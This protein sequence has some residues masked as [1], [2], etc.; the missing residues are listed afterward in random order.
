MKSQHIIWRHIFA[1]KTWLTPSN[2]LTL[3]RL[4]LAP[5]VVWFLYLG[6][7]PQAFITFVGAAATDLLDGHL[8]RAFDGQTHLGR[9]LDPIADKVLLLSSFGALSFFHGPLFHVPGWF[10]LALV[11]RECFMIMGSVFLITH[12]RIAQVQPLLAGKLSTCLQILFIA[13][14]FISYF[15]GWHVPVLNNIGLALVGACTFI[16]LGQYALHMLKA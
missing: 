7:W 14:L 15:A 10:L 6:A 2:G 4:L 9:L 5:V 13:W 12:H 1:D 8:A 3:S 11:A 16:S